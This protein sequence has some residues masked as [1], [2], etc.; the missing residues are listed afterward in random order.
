MKGNHS[1]DYYLDE[2]YNKFFPNV[3]MDKLKSKYEKELNEKNVE[4]F[5]QNINRI[6]EHS[7]AIM[8]KLKSKY[9][10]EFNPLYNLKRKKIE[11]KWYKKIR[12]IEYLFGFKCTDYIN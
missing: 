4:L 7:K 9:E 11:K 1:F 12:K 8:Y 2:F 10:N 6:K 5:K 3:D